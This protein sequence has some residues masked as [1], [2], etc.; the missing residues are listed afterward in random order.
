MNPAFKQFFPDAEKNPM[1]HAWFEG[2]AA[3][4]KT[5]K[6]KRKKIVKRELQVQEKYFLQKL[7]YMP[8]ENTIRTYGVDI[9]KRKKTETELHRV[10]SEM[11]IKVQ[12]RTSEL[13]A[14]KHLADIGTLAATVAHELRNPLGVINVAAYNLR[15][16]A[17]TGGRDLLKHVDNIEKK[18]AESGQIINNLLVYSKMKMPV[19][20]K[21]GIYE[22]LEECAAAVK[23]H[24]GGRKIQLKKILGPLKGLVIDADPLQIREIFTNLITNA[25]QALENKKGTVTVKAVLK[26]DNRLSISVKDDGMGINK[27]DMANIYKPFFTRKSKGTGLG[28]VICRDMVNMHN[29]TIDIKSSPGRGSI[30]TVNLP[31]RRI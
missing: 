6:G 26:P 13:V 19:F 15:K 21:T 25:Y 9:T 5:L 30:F 14:S 17:K 4:F 11:E 7:V 23:D 24:F 12:Q 31:T 29:G 18:V 8:V 20:G 2:V 3:I 22:L 28:L 10:Y 16:K 1:R 27:E